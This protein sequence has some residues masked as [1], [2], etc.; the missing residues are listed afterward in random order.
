MRSPECSHT[1]GTGQAVTDSRDTAVVGGGL[2]VVS[3]ADDRAAPEL[4]IPGLLVAFRLLSGRGAVG[5]ARLRL[6]RLAIHPAAEWFHAVVL[7]TRAAILV[8]LFLVAVARLATRLRVPQP[9]GSRGITGAVM[10]PRP[11][12][13]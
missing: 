5:C 1:A 2:F 6:D 8:G 11:L 10:H 7:V 12:C 3:P 9:A 4:G 13:S